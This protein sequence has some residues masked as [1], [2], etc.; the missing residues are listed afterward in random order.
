[1]DD[2][3]LSIAELRGDPLG[4]RARLEKFAGLLDGNGAHMGIAALE[5]RMSKAEG[6]LV[7]QKADFGRRIKELE[8]RVRD[9]QFLVGILVAVAAVHWATATYGE[10]NVKAV[11]YT[12]GWAVLIGYGTF[13]ILRA[14]FRLTRALRP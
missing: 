9:L 12:L 14:V 11:G 13:L 4:T 8:R 5:N 6:R 2:L 10:Q 1:M 7:E 3:E